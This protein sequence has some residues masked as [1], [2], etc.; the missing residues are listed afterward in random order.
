[1]AWP[2]HSQG[3]FLRTTFGDAEFFEGPS[4]CLSQGSEV[5]NGFELGSRPQKGQT[6]P[7][8]AGENAGES[9][10]ESRNA[11]NVGRSEVP[12]L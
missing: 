5:D 7:R 6:P 12:F 2:R 1:M 9:T 11:V 3:R 8:R 4:E 10:G